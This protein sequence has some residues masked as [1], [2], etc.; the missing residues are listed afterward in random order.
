MHNTGPVAR[1]ESPW[2]WVF[3]LTSVLAAFLLFQVQP[4]IGK[5]LLPWFGG[6]PGL[7]TT[8]MLF[9]QLALLAGYAYAHLLSALLSARGQALVHSAV[10]L[11]AASVLPILPHARHEPLA[12]GDPTA[13]I[14]LL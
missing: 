10:L 1:L 3:A 6:G 2:R 7:W 13:R 12:T 4:L 9:F 14:F 8:A 11:A 5:A